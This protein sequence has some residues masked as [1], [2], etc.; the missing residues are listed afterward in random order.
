MTYSYPSNTTDGDTLFFFNYRSDRMREIV[1]VFG[2]PDKP[3]EVDV[4]KDL[5]RPTRTCSLHSLTP[6][7]VAHHHD[8]PLQCRIPF[9]C[10]FPTSSN[11]ER[12]RRVAIDTRS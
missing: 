8:V 9:P 12:A 7:H 3:M 11:D 1:S 10:R 4:P 6:E 5:V 2:L